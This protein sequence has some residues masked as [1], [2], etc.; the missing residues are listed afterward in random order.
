MQ[1]PRVAS[2]PAP[3]L[4][5]CL[6]TVALERIK[7]EKLSLCS[8]DR[9]IR[10]S[11]VTSSGRQSKDENIK[12]LHNDSPTPKANEGLCCSETDT[13]AS[14]QETSSPC[15]KS[16]PLE[17]EESEG[18]KEVKEDSIDVELDLGLSISYDIDV[19]QSSDSSEEEPL[20]SFQEMMERVTK[21]PDTPQKEAFSE[22]STPGCRSSHSKTLRQCLVNPQGTSQKTLLWSSPAQLR[23]H[24]NIGLF[25]EAYSS[26]PCPAQVTRFLFKVKGKSLVQPVS[27]FLLCCFS[28]SFLQYLSYCMGL[29]PHAY[30]D[31]ELLLLLTVVGRISLETRRILQSN[32]EVSCLLYKMI[33][34]IREWSSMVSEETLLTPPI[35]F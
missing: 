32:V 29:C 1:P 20:I 26:S 16:T 3:N 13:A 12:P 9:G 24:L 34:N 5:A 6:P 22:P 10:N 21:P 23:L 14:L 8:K 2:S 30:S 28:W 18:S 25:E 15:M 35:C 11:P 7:L 33:N 4:A 31:D 27:P 17:E 19:T